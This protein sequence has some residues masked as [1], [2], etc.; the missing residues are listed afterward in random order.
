[1]SEFSERITIKLNTTYVD[2]SWLSSFTE[3][4]L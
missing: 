2:G 1:M 4:T 3:C